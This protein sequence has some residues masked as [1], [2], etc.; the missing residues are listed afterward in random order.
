MQKRHIVRAPLSQMVVD[1]P[2]VEDADMVEIRVSI[3]PLKYWDD[4]NTLRRE[5]RP[6]GDTCYATCSIDRYI[7]VESKDSRYIFHLM[8]ELLYQMVH[9]YLG[10]EL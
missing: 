7:R 10:I 2:H 9:T 5:L 1:A 8:R 6:V 3:T 4:P